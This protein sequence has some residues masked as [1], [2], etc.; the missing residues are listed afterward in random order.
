MEKGKGEGKNWRET[1]TQRETH[2]RGMS[3]K[4]M[5]EGITHTHTHMHTHAHTHQT[6]NTKAARPASRKST[7]EKKRRI[8]KRGADRR[9][10]YL[11]IDD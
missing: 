9:E 5:K 10:A 6:E 3:E 7:P 4:G 2:A 11:H 8:Q 1:H